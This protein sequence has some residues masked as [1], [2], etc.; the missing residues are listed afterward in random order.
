MAASIMRMVAS[1][2]SGHARRL[3][4][5]EQETV[6]GLTV[7]STFSIGRTELMNEAQGVGAHP[8]QDCG[9]LVASLT[10]GHG[11]FSYH[12]LKASKSS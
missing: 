5:P 6:H 8:Y 11:H 9:S 12:I 4:A 10:R 2:T 1:S 3:T 7:C